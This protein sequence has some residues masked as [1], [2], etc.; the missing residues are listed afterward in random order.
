MKFSPKWPALAVLALGGFAAILW[1]WAAREPASEL[2]AKGRAAIDKE[3]HRTAH[4]YADVLL[5]RDPNSSEALLLAGQASAGQDR[6]QEALAYCARV[7]DDGSPTA[8]EARCYAG[9]ILLVQMTNLP[10]AEEQYLRAVDQDPDNI[11]A[12]NRL[13]YTEGLG[14]GAWFA[15][16]R[17]VRLL[18]Q[19]AFGHVHLQ[20]LGTSVDGSEERAVLERY[21]QTTPDDPAV[22][23]AVARHETDRNPDRAILLLRRAV[24]VAPRFVPAQVELGQVLWQRGDEEEFL[25]WHAGLPLE[26]EDHP[27]VWTLCGDFARKRG[28]IGPAIRCFW[29]AVRRDANDRA[30]NYQLGQLL[31]SEGR[32]E[33][34]DRFLK[35]AQ[36]LEAYARA[37]EGTTGLAADEMVK[38]AELAEALELYWEA[39]GWSHLVSLEKEGPA[40]ERAERLIDILELLRSDG[41]EKLVGTLEETRE[42][43]LLHADTFWRESDE[44]TT[45]VIGVRRTV[46][47][48]PLL[49]SFEHLRHSARRSMQDVVQIAG[50][51]TI[52]LA[53][54]PQGRQHRVIGRRQAEGLQ[55]ARLESLDQNSETRQANERRKRRY[56][57]IGMFTLPGLGELVGPVVG[58][59]GRCVLLLL[60]HPCCKLI[61]FPESY[62]KSFFDPC[63]RRPRR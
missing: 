26:A 28:Q 31:V 19:G 42:D 17:R 10:R 61:T 6:Y 29:E 20:V 22:L 12:C 16:A 46:D 33:S 3:D 41:R 57:G 21:L 50:G 18:R 25:R 59:S 47:Q 15:I 35:R 30:T 54:A 62:R 7:P 60:R 32:G 58:P 56:V 55:Q 5:E 44:R 49:Q 23:T 48:L 8:V 39:Y 37:L 2:L 34:A 13:A 4:K 38:T 27:E 14:R 9:D 36:G 45:T 43:H 1:S 52:R 11:L 24:S 63:R 53:R 51:R 40:L